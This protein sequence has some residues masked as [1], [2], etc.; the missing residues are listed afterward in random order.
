MSREEMSREEMSREEMSTVGFRRFDTVERLADQ[1][2]RLIIGGIQ[3]ARAGGRRYLLG[4][5]GGRTPKPVFEAL[6]EQCAR[7]D[8]DCSHVVIAMM[9]DYLEPGAEPPRAIDA[10][11]LHSCRRFAEV[12]IRGL[13]NAGLSDTHRIPAA[14][15]WFPD[16]RNPSEYDRRLADAGGVDLFLVASGAS[17]GHVAFCG[18]GSPL[19]GTSSIVELAETTRQDNTVTFPSLGS[20]DD[21]PAYGVTVGLGTIR[22]LSRSVL[23]VIHGADKRKA[24]ERVRG[25]AGHEP[26]WPATFVHTCDRAEVWHDQLAEVGDGSR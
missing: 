3:Q 13:V 1:A 4:C 10:A 5:P 7:S 17:D 18:P 22:R 16:P 2:A 19:D 9:D 15:V 23:L 12:E 26:D 21:V 24:L 20:T 11:A 14:A 6:A 8:I 25:A